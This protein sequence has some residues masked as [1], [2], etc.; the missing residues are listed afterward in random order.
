MI[1]HFLFAVK[2]KVIA[3][4]PLL[5]GLTDARVAQ[6]PSA[7]RLAVPLPFSVSHPSPW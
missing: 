2:G 1:L 7:V 5:A 6:P 4:F 3:P